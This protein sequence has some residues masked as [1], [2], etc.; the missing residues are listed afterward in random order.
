MAREVEKLLS[1]LCV[2]LGFCLPPE[3][4]RRLS[5]TPPPSVQEFVAAVFR[6]EGLDA[7]TASRS[8]LRQVRAVVQRAFDRHEDDVRAVPPRR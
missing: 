3:D 1:T 4:R 5:T 2:D 7:E 6:A 8:L